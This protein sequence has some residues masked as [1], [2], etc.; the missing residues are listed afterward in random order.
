MK[1]DSAI[2]QILFILFSIVRKMNEIKIR[3]GGGPRKTT[4]SIKGNHPCFDEISFRAV[5]I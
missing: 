1:S 2:K 4:H 5:F 3:F